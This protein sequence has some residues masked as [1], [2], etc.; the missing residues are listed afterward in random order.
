M[1]SV[2]PSL[3]QIAVTGVPASACLRARPITDSQPGERVGVPQRDR[4]V[5]LRDS[6]QRGGQLELPDPPEPF[7]HGDRR[8]GDQ[9]QAAGEGSNI[10]WRITVV[11]DSDA[12]VTL[13]LPATTDCN[14]RSSQRT[15][16]A[17][18]ECARDFLTD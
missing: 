14:S 15:S 10:L 11:P 2:I 17:A 12:D 16:S 4:P 5:H 8:H 7:V 13:I 9:G 3:R 18:H 6:V 1:G